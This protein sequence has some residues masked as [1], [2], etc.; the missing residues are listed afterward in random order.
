MGLTGT[1]ILLTL[2]GFRLVSVPNNHFVIDDRTWEDLNGGL[3]FAK[4]D[5]AL[6]VYGQQYLYSVLRV[7]VF[8]QDELKRAPG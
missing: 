3:V 6:T 4:I 1:A 5:R 2:N 8:E 7:P